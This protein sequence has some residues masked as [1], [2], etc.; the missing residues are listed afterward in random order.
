MEN[1]TGGLTISE[2]RIFED[3]KIKRISSSR[4]IGIL[5]SCQTLHA[6]FVFKN[7]RSIVGSVAMIFL[8]SSR[9]VNFLKS[10]TKP[11]ISREFTTR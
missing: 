4:N 9:E 7:N 11:E 2:K 3:E 1:R 8:R 10:Q 5:V 6:P